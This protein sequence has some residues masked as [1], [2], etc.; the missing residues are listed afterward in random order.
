MKV[1]KESL[2]CNKSF[3]NDFES[4]SLVICINNY[5]YIHLGDRKIHHTLMKSVFMKI[6]CSLQEKLTQIFIK[7]P[8]LINIPNEVYNSVVK[9]SLKS[10]WLNLSL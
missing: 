5:K 9:Q 10:D 2:S 6:L 8:P 7:S 4:F 3:P 1:E